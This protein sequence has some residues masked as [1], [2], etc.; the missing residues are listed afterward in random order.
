MVDRAAIKSF[1]RAVAKQLRPQAIILFGSYA[2]GHPTPDSDV[3]LLVIMPKTRER[4]ER[5]SVRIRHAVPRNLPMDLLVRTPKEMAR[6]LRWGDVFV[7]E[8]MEKGQVMYEANDARVGAKDNLG[9][10]TEF[11][12]FSVDE[13]SVRDKL[14][15]LLD[16]ISAGIEKKK[17]KA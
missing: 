6:R 9:L 8:V 16:K 4:G 10:Y 14:Q 1:C 13:K 3:D 12:D 15:E 17:K 11:K 7:R 2:Y 5:M